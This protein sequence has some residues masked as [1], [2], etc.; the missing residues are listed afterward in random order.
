MFPRRP[1]HQEIAICR[2]PGRQWFMGFTVMINFQCL[3]HRESQMAGVRDTGNHNSRWHWWNVNCRCLGHQWN[4]N[5]WCPGHLRNDG[6]RDSGEWQH[7]HS[8][9]NHG[10]MR[11]ANVQDTVKILKFLTV[12]YFFQT[13]SHWYRLK[14]NNKK[15]KIHYLLYKLIWFMFKKNV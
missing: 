7:I 4:A 10:E 2:C 8:G 6:V 15:G 11:N 12:S 5:C 1:G 13:L 3:A 9:S 14:S